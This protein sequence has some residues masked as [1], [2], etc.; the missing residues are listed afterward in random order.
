[1]TGAGVTLLVAGLVMLGY[2]AWQ[3]YGTNYVSRQQQAQAVEEVRE[4]W[5]EPATAGKAEQ[6]GPKGA[7]TA[8]IRIPR[9]GRDYEMPVFHG[10]S[11]DVLAKGFGHFDHAAGPGEAGNYAL[12]AHR[13]THGEPLR[14]MPQLR[15]G[16][17]VEVETRSAVYVYRLDTDPN[18]LVVTFEDTWVVDARPDNPEKGGVEPIRHR[19]LITLT[20]CAELFHTD[21]RLIA[22]GHLV[23]TRDKAPS[24]A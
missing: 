10:T 9:F 18:D 19:R 16:D 23:Q 7:A 4:I 2:V 5:A 1:M 8:L 11:D 17:I 15:P 6:A 21:D 13:I 22:F 24:A 14:D 20:T 12:A 3:L